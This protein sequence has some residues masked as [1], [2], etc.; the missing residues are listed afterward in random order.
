MLKFLYQGDYLPSP[1]PSSD[2][3]DCSAPLWG[4]CD[5]TGGVDVLIHVHIYAI[6]KK[7]EV[8]ELETLALQKFNDAVSPIEPD[9]LADIV[10]AVYAFTSPGDEMRH[11]IINVALDG[12]DGPLS[13]ESFV[14]AL[15]Q[16]PDLQPFAAALCTA[17]FQ[18]AKLHNAELEGSIY[19]LR[20]NNGIV[21]AKL[22]EVQKVLAVNNEDCANALKERQKSEAKYCKLAKRLD[23]KS[24]EVSIL[25]AKL[26]IEKDKSTALAREVTNLQ[27]S[28]CKES[29]KAAAEKQIVKEQRQKLK[30]ELNHA[31]Q[32]IN[33]LKREKENLK[34]IRLVA[35]EVTKNIITE[36]LKIE[37]C[38]SCKKGFDEK[39]CWEVIRILRCGYCKCKHK[40]P[41]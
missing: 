25:Q 31:N 33:N 20:T 23:E 39:W 27:A 8:S 30:A 3:E 13:S 24:S 4:E 6:A 7:Y 17:S 22:E 1:K 5:Q 35:D 34:N 10:R 26:K 14:L 9:R 41:Q 11:A 38:R 40:Y 18:R 29:R 2:A 19:K 21:Q 32:L 12:L 36:R 15:K 28:T 16:D 37:K